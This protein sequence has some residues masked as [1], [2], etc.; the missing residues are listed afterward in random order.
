VEYSL[1]L[2]SLFETP[3][4]SL[5]NEEKSKF[6]MDTLDVIPM[7]STVGQ[8]VSVHALAVVCIA[9]NKKS[10]AAVLFSKQLNFQRKAAINNLEA[11]LDIPPAVILSNVLLELLEISHFATLTERII[12]KLTAL[13]DHSKVI[14]P[15][16]VVDF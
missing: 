5:S 4:S 15:L 12:Q 11:L 9:A 16:G 13:A 6:L 7:C 10:D 14:M 3:L 2:L 1:S 8:F